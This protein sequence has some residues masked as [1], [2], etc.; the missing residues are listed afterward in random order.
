MAEKEYTYLDIGIPDGYIEQ[1][2]VDRI[3]EEIIPDIA[4]VM[5]LL[6]LSSRVLEP[7]SIEEF[8]EEVCPET[9][10]G[11]EMLVEFY[12]TT[13]GRMVPQCKTPEELSIEQA[14]HALRIILDQKESEFIDSY[15]KA[16][17]PLIPQKVIIKLVELIP[18]DM[19]I[20]LLEDNSKYRKSHPLYYLF[21]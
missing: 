21:D 3:V 15:K 6:N 4:Q 12:E 17:F 19:S 10:E 16:V 1:D 8:L 9:E 5:E 14:F 7:K 18:Q 11:K 13:Y 20:K 2:E